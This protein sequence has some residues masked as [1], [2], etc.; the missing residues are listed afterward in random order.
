MVSVAAVGESVKT[1]QSWLL[2]EEIG[3]DSVSGTHPRPIPSPPHCS[4]ALP[5]ANK[6]Y[7]DTPV[8]S[9]FLKA[10]LIHPHIPLEVL[11]SH[12]YPPQPP[13]PYLWSQA[14]SLNLHIPFPSRAP[15][16]VTLLGQQPSLLTHPSPD[17]TTPT[18]TSF[19]PP[20]HFLPH[21]AYQNY[22][23]KVIIGVGATTTQ[24]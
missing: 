22:Y 7:H 2:L 20:L 18:F 19:L 4:T 10:S 8:L 5:L 3:V 1:E 15:V 9:P 17:L 21:P 14:C 6:H 16:P 13:T 11:L 24:I 23:R 12:P